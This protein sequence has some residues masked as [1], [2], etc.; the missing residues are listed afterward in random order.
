MVLLARESKL[1]GC[2]ENWV[3]AHNALRTG[4]TKHHHHHPYFGVEGTLSQEP[5][6]CF[7]VTQLRDKVCG[8]D[9]CRVLWRLRRKGITSVQSNNCHQRGRSEMAS[10]PNDFFLKKP[11]RNRRQVK[12]SFKMSLM[13]V[14]VVAQGSW[15]R[16]V[17]MR[18]RVRFL[19]LLS[20]LRIWRCC[21]LW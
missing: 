14:P 2:Y 9:L 3:N 12:K 1:W 5:L 10:P 4:P 8:P 15:T 17:S 6:V 20:G 19:A 21:E 16:L 18:T 11:L 13:G 7:A